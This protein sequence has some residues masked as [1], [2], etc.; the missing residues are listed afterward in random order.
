M[1]LGQ[2]VLRGGSQLVAPLLF[3]PPL[4]LL[5]SLLAV[6]A[7]W[8]VLLQQGPNKVFYFLDPMSSCPQSTVA[9][10]SPPHLFLPH[11]THT[12]F[13]LWSLPTVIT[14]LLVMLR[15][16]PAKS[17]VA[18]SPTQVVLRVGTQLAAPLLLLLP[19]TY[20][21][22]LFQRF[23]MC[24]WSCSTGPNKESRFLAPWVK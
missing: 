2:V 20:W 23:L 13:L 21:F 24:S 18:L 12:H 4:F 5:W 10:G 15:Y 7:G 6:L 8:L 1:L 9:V 14:G 19:P 17:P 11:P 16:V 22:G 3:L